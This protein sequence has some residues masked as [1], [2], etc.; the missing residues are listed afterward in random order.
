MGKKHPLQDVEA[1]KYFK[2]HM[3]DEL[4]SLEELRDALKTMDDETFGHHV[5]DE[6]N[7]F[8]NWVRDIIKDVRLADDL[9]RLRTRGKTLQR[10]ED[11]I[12]WLEEELKSST[13]Y[14]HIHS[15]VNQFLAGALLG[16]LV[17]LVL[18]K[19]FGVF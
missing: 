8:A 10:V 12:R 18:A 1:D 6:R 15:H 17:G 2:L 5:N 3:G 9:Q 11:R 4:K 7:D 13:P 14:L 19:L 16:L